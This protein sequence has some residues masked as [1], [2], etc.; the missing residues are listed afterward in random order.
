MERPFGRLSRRPKVRL[1]V[2]YGTNRHLRDTRRRMEGRSSMHGLR[3]A[4]C[5]PD[6]WGRSGSRAPRARRKT[7]CVS[8]IPAGSV[9]VRRR[10]PEHKSPCQSKIGEGFSAMA[11]LCCYATAIGSFT[12][13]RTGADASICVTSWY[14]LSRSTGVRPAE[15]MSSMSWVRVSTWALLP[16]S[17]SL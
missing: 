13:R 12:G 7:A 2:P 4:E 5:E 15:T 1:Q 14:R 9:F 3:R 8:G 11:C 17:P 6:C 16:C 10:S